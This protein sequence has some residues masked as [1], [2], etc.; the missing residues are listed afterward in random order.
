MSTPEKSRISARDVFLIL[1]TAST[2]LFP[3]LGQT[4]FR[5]AEIYFADVA[6]AMVERGDW[7]IPHFRGEPFF[8]KPAFAYW[9]LA[10]SFK[11]FGF[12]IGSARLAPALATLLVITATLWVGWLLW[13]DRLSA[14]YSAWILVGTVSFMTFGRIAMSD[15]FL[16]LCS[17]VAIGL[18]IFC[19]RAERPASLAIVGLAAV[20]GLG[21][22][23]KGPV[24]LLIPGI[25]LLCLIWE[26]R[27]RLP[28]ISPA[29][30]L[31]SAVVF[32]VV[33]LGWFGAVYLSMGA[34]PLRFFFV[35]ENLQRFSGEA[36]D[37]GRPVW[38][39]L[40][41]Y[42]VQGAPWSLLM[43]A[44]AFEFLR[45][46]LDSGGRMLIFWMLL[47][48]GVL[49]LSQ[50]KLDYYLLPLYPA[51][52]LIVGRYL[53]VASWSRGLRLLLSIALTVLGAV[54][55][56]L[57]IPILRLPAGWRLQ[58]AVL[59]T[60]V[61]LLLVAGGAC[62]VMAFRPTSAAALRVLVAALVVGFGI[63]SIFVLPAF[64]RGEPNAAILAAASRERL[65]QP[66]LIIAGHGDPTQIHRDLLFHSRVI[67]EESNDLQS[68]ALSPRP[69]L[70]LAGVEEAEMLKTTARV[71]EVGS[72][73]YLR[74]EAFNLRGLRRPPVPRRLVLLANFTRSGM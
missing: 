52:A 5:R 68:L 9:L 42:L 56:L 8:D 24:A 26:R 22:F 3:A 10:A 69:Y 29:T 70:L 49:T 51:A 50:G 19:Y 12:S 39:Y 55:V 59:V 32:S 14:L 6:R 46:K 35:R 1:G 71:R 74:S 37:V 4:P 66:S 45:R 21:F 43:P 13:E 7:L 67:L 23:T 60:I 34:E 53:R 57:P 47:V 40:A 54:L 72:Y 25:G 28:R 58:G 65:V 2:L 64:Y 61:S 16:V 31:W 17:T 27:G 33:A 38:F 18:G 20:L 41:T 15:M 44:A 73:S 30:A 62:L 63:V 48:G 11:V 36:H